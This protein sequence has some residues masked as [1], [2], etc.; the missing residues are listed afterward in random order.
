MSNSTNINDLPVAKENIQMTINDPTQMQQQQQQPPLQQ[1]SPPQISESQ[2]NVTL[3]PNTINQ[4]VNELHQATLSGSTKL[5]SRDIPID[6]LPIQQDVETSPNFVPEVSEERKNY[7]P[8]ED[9]LETIVKK[10]NIKTNHQN[11]IENMYNE[12]QTPILLGVLYFLFQLPIF[13]KLLYQTF[14]SL[15]MNDGNLSIN[16]YI[17]YSSLFSIVFYFL[18][19][20]VGIFDTF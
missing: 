10:Q 2:Q 16:G 13:K 15:F 7:I 5:V 8:D 12:L 6:T 3:D 14:P 9:D 11:N 20:L 1:Q 17:F 4:I 19:R 18:N